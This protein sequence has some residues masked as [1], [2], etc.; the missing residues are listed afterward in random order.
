M[1]VPGK[2]N[3]KWEQL[4]KHNKENCIENNEAYYYPTDEELA[5]FAQLF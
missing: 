5:E 3:E 4:K 1:L 2:P